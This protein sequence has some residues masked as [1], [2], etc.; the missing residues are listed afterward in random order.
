MIIGY[1]TERPRAE[2]Y[3]DFEKKFVL[4]LSGLKING[5]SL[6]LY[7]SYVRGDYVAG[8]SDID[9]V[10][11]FPDDVVI[12]KQNLHRVSMVLHQALKGNN[13]P[14]QVTVTDATTMRDGRFNSYDESFREYFDEEARIT[15]TDYRPQI[16]YELP[17]M[18]EQVPIRFNLRK[19]R[20]GLLF[21]EHDKN[22]DYETFLAK[23]NKS[24]D[25]VSR[26]SKQIIYLI[27]GELRK[28]RFSAVKV[29]GQTFPEVNL[30]LLLRIKQL[31]NNPHKF[32]EIYKN[33]DQVLD[34][35]NSA[36]TLMEEM[37]RGYLQRNI[38]KHN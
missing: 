21:A 36:V 2:N 29:I 17:T 37:I 32:D 31:Y 35:W 20:T 26:G 30:E 6:M 33:P 8:R 15:G 16:T 19:T 4:G 9:A 28:N 34:L 12:D 14:F 11:I 18:N 25:A 10:L 7:G 13:I 5:L 24:L 1:N 22:E 3:T 38:R 23:F 27:D